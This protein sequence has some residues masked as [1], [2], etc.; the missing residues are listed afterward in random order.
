MS[1]L[2]S[3]EILI[4]IGVLATLVISSIALRK[5]AQNGTVVITQSN[6]G[7]VEQIV[8]IVSR[9]A[10]LALPDNKSVEVVTDVLVDLIDYGEDLLDSGFALTEQKLMDK[11]IEICLDAGIKL[12]EEQVEFITLGLQLVFKFATK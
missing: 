4:L 6:L 9:M 11:S 3:V 7:D 5:G 1:E 10:R 12:T 8:T 2:F